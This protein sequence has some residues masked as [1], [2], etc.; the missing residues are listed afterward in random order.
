MS[1]N[2]NNNNKVKTNEEAELDAVRNYLLKCPRVSKD[3]RAIK[4]A[5]KG[6]DQ[7]HQR[8]ERDAKLFHKFSSERS[9]TEH[10]NSATT[11]TSDNK[12]INDSDIAVQINYNDVVDD[13]ALMEWQDIGSESH[14]PTTNESTQRH[15]SNS[16]DRH[17]S[18]LGRRLAQLAI[19]S[20][21]QAATR[22]SS[23]L[24]AI[25]VALHAAL[26]GT[27]LDFACTGIPLV[28]EKAG[29]F[30]P[31]IRELPKTQFLPDQWD[32]NKNNV[33]LR[34]RKNGVGS[35]LLT[36]VCNQPADGTTDAA[37]GTRND[38]TDTN[39]HIQLTPANTKEPPS[40][41]LSFPL[42]E[43]MNLESFAT[44][45]SGS[46][47]GI[48]P[49]LHYKQLH[50]LMM[51]FCNTFDLGQVQED[52]Y[53]PSSTNSILQQQPV[54]GYPPANNLRLST[55]SRTVVPDHH[56]SRE[57]YQDIPSMD[58]LRPNYPPGDFR[59][60]LAPGGFVDPTMLPS[61]G[62][63]LV[64]QITP[65]LLLKD[66]HRVEVESLAWEVEIG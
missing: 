12:T 53:P 18:L 21:S 6:L 60:D 11:T 50:V 14:S 41:G 3:S 8:I 58:Q 1:S 13:A 44:A 31:P 38:S 5:L 52:G 43:Y 33:V 62:G 32:T 24:A 39:V 22:V 9:S 2:N 66:N 15:H 51:N 36:V 56:L 35:V 40:D 30:A 28:E 23:P 42:E 46:P 63:N 61:H 64:D 54:G 57:D 4:A 47:G 45:Q 25:A 19:T 48:L 49:A 55:P 29:G 20:M 26:R 17:D 65:C 59:G 27:E 37:M 16:D 7:E 10:P 34:Y